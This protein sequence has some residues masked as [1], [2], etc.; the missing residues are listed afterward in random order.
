ML[1][2]HRDLTVEA[3][4]TVQAALDLFR[5]KPALGFTDCLMLE[6]A[7]QAGHLPLGTFDR[8]LA[9]I[10]GAYKLG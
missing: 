3:P 8:N 6:L 7:R 1:L 4:Q 10:P 9:R 5:Q 2:D